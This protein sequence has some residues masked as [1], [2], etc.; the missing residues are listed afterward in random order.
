MLWY[1]KQKMGTILACRFCNEK[2]MK[3]KFDF[4]S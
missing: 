2:I 4:V 3:I 1:E